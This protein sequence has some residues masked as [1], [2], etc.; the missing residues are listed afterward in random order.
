MI[1]SMRVE[2]TPYQQLSTT[3]GIKDDL[4]W[5][6]KGKTKVDMVVVASIWIVRSVVKS[7]AHL[8]RKRGHLETFAEFGQR[9]GI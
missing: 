2:R 5:E 7:D 4:I 3:L 1:S 6:R 9:T 8:T